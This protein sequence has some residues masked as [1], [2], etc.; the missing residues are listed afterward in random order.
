MLGISDELAEQYIKFLYKKDENATRKGDWISKSYEIFKP[1]F[2]RIN[3]SFF[4]D[5]DQTQLIL[6]AIKFVSEHGWKLLQFYSFDIA[7]GEFV[8]KNLKVFINYGI[9]ASLF[10]Y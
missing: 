7:S 2:T 4:F 9:L 3:L 1:G 10:F 6:N 8:H 5:K